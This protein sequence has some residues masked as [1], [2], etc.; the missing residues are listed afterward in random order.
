MAEYKQK[1]HYTPME[2]A[3]ILN[4]SMGRFT[5]LVAEGS[6]PKGR[7]GE[8]GKR[9]YTNQDLGYMQREWKT[10][11]TGRFLMYTLPLIAVLAIILVLTVVEVSDKIRES[12][13][14]PTP[15]APFGFG[16]PPEQYYNPGTD[17]PTPTPS[18]S[19]TP[20]YQDIET[21]RYQMQ[22]QKRRRE[23]QR[24]ATRKMN[25]PKVFRPE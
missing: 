11:T 23:A 8:D 17:W 10:Q 14:E 5:E 3:R 4:I 12:R 19:P 13:V 21:Y 16:A 25:R 20:V 22:E 6:L 9:Y 1:K 2:V 15:T 7:I 24:Q 18:A